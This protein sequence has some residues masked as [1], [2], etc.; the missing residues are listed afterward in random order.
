MWKLR[1]ERI[2]TDVNG[3]RSELDAEGRGNPATEQHERAPVA[4]PRQLAGPV[5]RRALAPFAATEVRAV[6]ALEVGRGLEPEEGA[7]PSARR[8]SRVR[9]EREVVLAR[10]GVQLA[11]DE[12][13]ISAQASTRSIRIAARTGTRNHLYSLG[14]ILCSGG[15]ANLPHVDTIAP[16][17]PFEPS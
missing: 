14:S 3:E 2:G 6:E 4:L 16:V 15:C 8:A 17:P 11:D 9:E 1:V 10:K 12:G 7:E 13:F 5:G